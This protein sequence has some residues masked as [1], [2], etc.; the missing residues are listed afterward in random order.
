MFTLH[1]S[2]LDEICL[3]YQLGSSLEITC[4]CPIIQ[5][6]YKGSF[7]IANSTGRSCHIDNKPVLIYLRCTTDE[8]ELIRCKIKL[9]TNEYAEPRIF[10]I[11]EANQWF[12]DIHLKNIFTCLHMTVPKAL[13]MKEVHCWYYDQVFTESSHSLPFT[14]RL[15]HSKKPLLSAI[16][17]R[18]SDGT[19][20]ATSHSIGHSSSSLIRGRKGDWG[21]LKIGRNKKYRHF[22]LEVKLF[23][24]YGTKTEEN[25]YLENKSKLSWSTE[26]G[27]GN[28]DLN[29]RKITLSA[30]VRDVAEFLCIG[31]FLIA[32][33][34]HW[35]RRD[36]KRCN[37]K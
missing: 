35:L 30:S 16:E 27:I 26:Q 37:V 33:L 18:A 12:H 7:T 31:F 25:F 14:M 10:D 23:T 4:D 24:L 32:K 20:T 11:R 3:K 6:S 21:L 22:R 1:F 2:F 36:K 8:E 13:R 29:L 28:V 19:V 5:K 17:V 9:H 34:R 15:V